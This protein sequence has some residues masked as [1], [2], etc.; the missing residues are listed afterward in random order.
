MT[1]VVFKSIDDSSTTD[2]S[3]SW[4]GGGLNG[5]TLGVQ[6]PY[7]LKAER[8]LSTFD[9]PQVFQVSY[10]YALPFGRGKAFGSNM[11]KVLNAFVGGWQTN[12]IIRLSSGRPI[13]T[14]VGISNP[15]IPSFPS[16]VPGSSYGQRPNLTGKLTRSNVSLQR[17][18]QIPN[19]P[20]PPDS[21]FADPSAL[22][23]PD[24]YTLG[25][26]PRTIGSVRQP[27]ARVASLSIFKEFS[28]SSIR[29][30]MRFEYR[31]E[32]F[33]AFNHPQFN[34]VDAAAGSPTFRPDHVDRP[35]QSAA[36]ADGPEVLFGKRP[37]AHR[38]LPAPEDRRSRSC[39]VGDGSCE[40]AC[41]EARD[42]RAAH[43]AE[44]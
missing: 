44:D 21:Y 15:T 20:N 41:C 11:N 12:G 19:S 37:R 39:A 33:N 35:Q 3:I 32:A 1:Y 40:N 29:E 38:R 22:S 9:I 43:G 6:N 2:D 27:G 5:L 24:P 8:S 42:Q 17:T 4:L 26:A 16:Q 14:A 23:V 34:D 31:L 36:G 25:S 28:L 7:D 30:G 13:I 18:I 10:V